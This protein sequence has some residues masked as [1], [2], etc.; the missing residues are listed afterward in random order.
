MDCSHQALLSMGFP[1]QEYWSR[2]PFPPP[3]DL[4]DPGIEPTPPTSAA[5]TGGLFTTQ[6]SSVQ[7]LSHV[8]LFATPW[9]AAHQAS[10]SLTTSATLKRP[11][12]CSSL[13]ARRQQE[14]GQLV[15]H[16]PGEAGCLLTEAQ[17]NEAEPSYFVSRSLHL[18]E[19]WISEWSPGAH[20]I[21]KARYRSH[22][23]GWYVNFSS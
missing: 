22:S 3:E 9:I 21:V 16:R 12:H 19:Q 11:K 17:R 20:R 18:L 2:L 10:L 14:R 5:L 23:F 6:F 1:R 7:S 13:Q 15:P 8:Q 4:P